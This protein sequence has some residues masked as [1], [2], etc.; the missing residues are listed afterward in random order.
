[1]P[2][3]QDLLKKLQPVAEL[4]NYV[5]DNYDEK[6]MNKEVSGNSEQLSPEDIEKMH[7]AESTGG[8]YLKNDKSSAS[9]N[10][11]II[12]STREQAEKLAKQQGIDTNI[13]NPLR[14][15]A[16]LMTALIKNSERVL[17]NS[18][19]GP[20]EPNARNIYLM[21]KN[22][23]QGG[24]NALNDPNSPISKARFKEVDRL[25][26]RM[27]KKEAEE[28]QPAKNLLDLLDIPEK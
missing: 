25:L 26:K 15:D 19:N 2:Y 27:P 16:N 9:G 22:G 20:Y 6:A 10:Y 28:V 24:L 1:M 5:M 13:A 8:K 21:H 4:P 3:F 11:Q 12:D 18:E 14:K 17:E 23:V 7:Y